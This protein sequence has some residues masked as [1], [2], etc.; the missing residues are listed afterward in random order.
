[1]NI[2]IT[3]EKI[4]SCLAAHSDKDWNYSRITVEVLS[5]AQIPSPYAL[6]V[7]FVSLAGKQGQRD[8]KLVRNEVNWG[9]RHAAE[10]GILELVSLRLNKALLAV[11]SR[12]FGAAE[13]P[14]VRLAKRED[15]L[16]QGVTE[17]LWYQVQEVLGE[18]FD[19]R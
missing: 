11:A 5:L 14:V 6:R 10:L 9:D 15:L 17:A 8:L 19:S 4:N 2:H 3:A 18:E 12:S 7:E 16:N 1:M 13:H